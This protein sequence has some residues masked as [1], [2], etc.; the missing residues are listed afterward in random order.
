VA[1]TGT[2]FL[3]GTTVAFGGVAA[4]N[5]VVNSATSLTATTPP[6]TAGPVNVTV[7]N[8]NGSATLTGGFTYVVPGAVLLNE[9]FND[10]D[11][12]GWSVSPLGNAAG[13]SVTGGSLTY[14]G[15]G[16][17][18]VYRGDAGWSDYTF[19][20]AFRLASLNNYPGGIRGRV[21]PATGASYAVWLYPASGQIALY[22]ATGWNID[23]PGLT[24]LASA[25]GIA[26]DAV[27]FHR[28]RLTFQGSSIQV[29]YDG[30]LAISV[31]D[32]TL[33]AGGVAFDVSNQP[34]S[35]DDVLVTFTP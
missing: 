34:I 4:T 9:D 3:S 28:L 22:R 31:T 20:A 10:G 11:M 6:G 19:E 14:N 12:A 32:A 15:G 29:H 26:F 35:F 21:N 2:G 27:N 13:W 5:V 7:S 33:A 30:A 24:H 16:H 25:S 1:L 8:A 18:Q 23:S 17:T